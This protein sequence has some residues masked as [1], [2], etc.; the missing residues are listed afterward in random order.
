MIATVQPDSVPPPT[1][2]E[3]DAALFS[4]QA[5]MLILVLI[6]GALMLVMGLVLYNRVRRRRERIA[7][8]LAASSASPWEIAGSRAEIDE[9]DGLDG[10]QLGDDD[11][12]PNEDTWAGA[13]PG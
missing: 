3:K 12:D 6:V 11:A 4:A 1:A 10:V 2:S 7:T 5:M 9:D 8:A 13:P